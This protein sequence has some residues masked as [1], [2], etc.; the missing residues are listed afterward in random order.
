MVDCKGVRKEIVFILY[1]TEKTFRYL[2]SEQSYIIRSSF[3]QF[4]V[5]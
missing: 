4:K 5:N 2:E 1:L 3:R